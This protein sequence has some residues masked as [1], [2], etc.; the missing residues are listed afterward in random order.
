M[1]RSSFTECWVG[2]V[3]ISP[4]VPTTGNQRQVHVHHVVAPKLHA[5]LA[6]GLEERQRLDVAHR[7][8]DLHHAHV[9]IA[10]A[11]ADAA[12]D[13]IGDVRNDLHGGA[14]VVAAPLL[15]DHALVN[16]PGGE[17]AV[18]ARGGAHEALV[19]S[20]VEIGLGAVLGDEHFAVLKR[21][22]GARIDVD[23]GIQ[24]HHRDLEAARLENRAE[25][26]AAMPLPNEET[27]PPVTNTKR[28]IV[29]THPQCRRS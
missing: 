5:H 12:L 9:R 14:Q 11:E 27:T 22:H 24:L 2:L 29:Q 15:G 8:A 21:T 4:E 28:L 20:E 3:L 17:I 18:A 7:A 25:R 6:D 13:L 23:V 16:A 19:V 26:G 1:P 10:R